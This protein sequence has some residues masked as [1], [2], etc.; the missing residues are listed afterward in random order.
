MPDDRRQFR[1]WS[2]AWLLVLAASGPLSAQP[3]APAPAPAPAAENK[4]VH[5]VEFRQLPLEDALRLISRQT[6]L[7]LV[8][9]QEAG[10]AKVSL[11]LQEIPARSLIEE[12]CR[13]NNL[14]YRQDTRS[15]VIRIMLVSEFQR[16]LTSFREEQTQVFSVLYPNAVSIA[17]AVADLYG[18]RVQLALGGDESSEEGR[19]LNERFNRF[20]MVD[21]RSQGLGIFSS[22]GT[23]VTDS[24][25]YG[26]GG[27]NYNSGSY[28]SSTAARRPA[29]PTGAPAGE[30]VAEYRALTP[31]QAEAVSRA[32]EGQASA[33]Q[34]ALLESLRRRQANIYVRVIRRNNL[35][36]VRTGDQSALEEIAKLVRRL[37]VPTPTIL[38]EV[39]VLS[40]ALSDGFGSVFD[41]QFSDGSKLAGGFTTGEANPPAGD[42]LSGSARRFAN[43]IPG[44]TGVQQKDLIFQFVN[45]SFRVRMQLLEDKN[46]VTEMATPLLLTANNEV[47][48]LFVGEERPIVRNISS[49]VVVNTNNTSVTPNTTIEFR[50]VGTTLLITPSINSD[51]TVTLRMLQENS[52]I[53][54]NG[55]TIPVVTS[56]GG[57]VSQPVDVVSTRT[58]SGTVVAKDGLMLAVGGLIEENVT[59]SRAE[60][61]VLGKI[62]TL[63]F[64][65]RRQQTGR[66]R[67]EL[68]IMIRPHV[69]STPAE[70]EA[71]G[72]RLMA[73]LSIHPNGPNPSGTMK[74]FNA[75][76]PVRPNLPRSECDSIFRFHS[77]APTDY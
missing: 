48:R 55:A 75:T 50:P 56:S 6:G 30:A 4:I 36:V 39:K 46:R 21:Q 64:F 54:S 45:D 52:K 22:G 27:Q 40:V 8:A 2:L 43:M 32:R 24:R 33:E 47:S 31:A 34:Q 61:P 51:R 38:L 23:T 25:T 77:V 76:E 63:G 73:D 28:T 67:N 71:L 69:L 17:S 37:D 12:L 65:F 10:R 49:Q 66:T 5:Q 15:G 18:D 19:D 14:W 41:Y 62:P 72:R 1:R 35:I 44:G 16:D 68:I 13:A 20:D 60:V 9:S 3:A 70:S 53:I 26:A 58:L 59:D 74:S 42:L 7:N 29:A 57:I 11:F